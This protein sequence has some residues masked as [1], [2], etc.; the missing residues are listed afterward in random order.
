MKRNEIR[1]ALGNTDWRVGWTSVCVT[2]KKSRLRTLSAVL[3]GL[4]MLAGIAYLCL[5]L[6][7]AFRSETAGIGATAP[8]DPRE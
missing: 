2:P 3:M 5:S 6:T 8:E 4:L 7:Q 1:S